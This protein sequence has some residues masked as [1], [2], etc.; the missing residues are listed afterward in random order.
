MSLLAD[1]GGPVRLGIGDALGCV[2]LEPARA[3]TRLPVFDNSQMDGFAVRAAD[4]AAGVALPVAARIY[5]GSPA[6][7]LAPGT[8]A[9][10]MTGAPIPPG[11]DAIA[12]ATLV[13]RPARDV[14]VRV[15]VEPA[16]LPEGGPLD[17]SLR[18]VGPFNVLNAAGAAAAI[19][20]VVYGNVFE[21][22]VRIGPTGQ[23]EPAL[24]ESWEISPDG[25]GRWI[26][27]RKSRKASIW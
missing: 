10:I 19:D 9:A 20:E 27:A 13:M 2:L 16:T 11:A 23:V 1:I 17:L 15:L 21:G 8:A 14:D 3:A 12:G 6:T 25:G 22:L 7:P 4:V 18:M 26:P 24:A 5:A